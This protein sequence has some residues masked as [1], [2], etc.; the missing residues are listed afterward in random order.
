[1]QVIQTGFPGLLVIKP[2]VFGDQRGFFIENYNQK[3]FE[4]IGINYNFVQDNHSRSTKGVIRGMHFQLPP[5]HQAKL[6]RVSRG[7]ALDVVLDLRIE[8]PTYGKAFGIELDDVELTM[9][10]IPPGFAH[11][12]Q[13][14]SE[15]CDFQY[16]VSAFYA[17]DAERG[18]SWQDDTV[19]SFWKTLDVEPV[20]SE[21]DKQFTKWDKNEIYFEKDF[22][23]K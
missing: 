12:F 7:K 18:I 14:L 6:V 1:M 13:V 22:E 15:V 3:K 23:V 20:V 5:Y 16:K 10:M 9:L 4:E 21:K 19:K 8:S 2:D 11:G 17:P